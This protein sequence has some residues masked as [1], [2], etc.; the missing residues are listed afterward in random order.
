VTL[1]SLINCMQWALLNR[2]PR[3]LLAGVKACGSAGH[4]AVR[5]RCDR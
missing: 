1:Y 2:N 4:S 3:I 5:E